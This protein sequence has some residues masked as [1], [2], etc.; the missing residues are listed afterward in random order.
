MTEFFPCLE[1]GKYALAI[2]TASPELGLAISN[3]SEPGRSHRW[4]LGRSMSTHLHLHLSEF[5]IPQRWDDLAFVAVAKGPG[6]FTGTRLGI[7]TARTLAQHLGIPL[8][9]ISTLAALGWATL[10]MQ[11]S[12]PDEKAVSNPPVAIAIEMAAQRDDVFGAIYTHHPPSHAVKESPSLPFS[13][14]MEDTVMTTDHWQTT[15]ETWRSP[16][17]RVKADGGLGW[18]APY[19]LELAY[20]RW[21]QGDRPHWSEALPYYGQSPV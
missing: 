18:T 7:V 19:L 15:L 16:Y 8:F 6:G 3:F 13:P 5:L 1:A 9:P 14:A 17:H 11:S 2:H 10:R 21:Q 4:D 12:E 20:D